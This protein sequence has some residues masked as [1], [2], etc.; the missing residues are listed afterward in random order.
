MEL[1]LRMPGI[2]AQAQFIQELTDRVIDLGD[3]AFVVRRAHDDQ[4]LGLGRASHGKASS[5][6]WRSP[7]VTSPGMRDGSTSCVLIAQ[8]WQSSRAWH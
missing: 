2:E 1:T 3:F 8:Q 4:A 7:E 6:R 5:A